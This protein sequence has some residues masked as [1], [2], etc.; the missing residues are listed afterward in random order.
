MPPAVSLLHY[1]LLWQPKSR[2]LQL[3]LLTSSVGG[4]WMQE[5]GV[6]HPGA[7]G[8]DPAQGLKALKK[9]AMLGR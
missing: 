7:C 8:Q 5:E 6:T 3:G 1:I 9:L 4:P 2:K